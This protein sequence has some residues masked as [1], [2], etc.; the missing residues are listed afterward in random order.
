[1]SNNRGM[2]KEDVVHIYNGILGKAKLLQSCP[3]LCDPI[4]LQAPLSMGFS[5]QEYW[6]VLPFPSPG[7][8]PDPGIEPISPEPSGTF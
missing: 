3:I 1:M 6:S 5:R 4:A 7:D 2:D 8:P